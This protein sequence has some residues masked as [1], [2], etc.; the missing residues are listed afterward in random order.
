MRPLFVCAII[1]SPAI[2]AAQKPA[3]GSTHTPPVFL[4]E[5][6]VSIELQSQ[7]DA[8]YLWRAHV[9]MSGFSSKTDRAR[10]D[11]KSGGKIVATTKCDISID[12]N[13]ATG[14]CAYRDKPIK[15]K[16]AIEADLVYSDDQTDKDYLVRTFKVNV[17]NVM[18]QW[19]SW[20]ITPDDTL[21]AAWMYMG[22]DD[23]TNS[24]YRR[25]TLYI[26]FATG[27]VMQ[28]PTMRC[29][30]EGKKI[31]DI[32]ISAQ[33]GSDTEDIEL[34]HQPKK[35]DRQTYHWNRQKFLLEVLWGKRDT[36]KH[37]MKDK[38]PKD[39]VLSDNPGKW[40]CNLRHD[41]KV[42]RQ[43]NFVVDKDGMIQ[44]DEI[45]SGKKAIPTVSP[46][47]VLVDLRFTKDSATYDERI[48]PAEMKKSMGFGLPWP[49]HPKVKT[50]Q[51]SYPAKSGLPDPK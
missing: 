28:Q 29:T 41:G 44:Q 38:H 2:A 25:P 26:T 32:A 19:E 37:D 17:V 5:A 4:D 6:S 18:G 50:I 11:W 24:T 43:I 8:G 3:P 22:N 39:L 16:G 48:N 33:S 15:A 42:I 47:V 46:K 12:D 10:L 1:L 27:K 34:D 36:L 31:P 23:S 13:Y 14:S 45:Q 35:G 9:E 49:D 30:A 40:E 7:S 20:Q 51:G 21:S